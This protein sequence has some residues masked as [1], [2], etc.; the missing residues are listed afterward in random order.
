MV[1]VLCLHTI[2]LLLVGD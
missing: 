2:I 1:M